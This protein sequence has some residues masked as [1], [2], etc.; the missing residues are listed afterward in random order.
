MN[1]DEIKEKYNMS[2]NGV[3]HIGAHYGDEVSDNYIVNGIT[4]IFLFEPVSRTF[5]ILESR[6]ADLNA[7]IYAY[8]VALGS[9]KGTAII[10]INTNNDGKSTSL[11][12]P[13]QHL[14]DH[15]WVTFEGTEEVEVDMLDNYDTK[16]ANMINIDV[17]GYELEVFKGASNTLSKIDYIISEVN[18][19]EMYENN[20]FVNE[21]D[22]YLKD[23][24]FER[25]ETCWP[26]T[27]YNW[28]DALY[29][30]NKK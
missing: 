7:N 16:D 28:G 26:D 13:K 14:I 20:V 15:S 11:L 6:M 29:I 22:S 18:R 25:V 19:G 17:Q 30:K 1:F 10:N 2:I 4:E 21:L 8:Q 9:K 3:I 27:W 24:G 23:F 12:K 5:K